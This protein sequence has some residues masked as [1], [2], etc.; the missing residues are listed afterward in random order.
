[1]EFNGTLTTTGFSWPPRHS[2][3]ENSKELIQSYGDLMI[4]FFWEALCFDE[5]DLEKCPIYIG[6]MKQVGSFF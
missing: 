5:N 2:Q 3:M 6:E 4:Y 1:V